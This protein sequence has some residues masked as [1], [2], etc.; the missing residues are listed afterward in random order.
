MVRFRTGISGS[1]LGGIK[2]TEECL[3]FCGKHNIFSET[4]HVEAN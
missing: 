1:H 4:L 2:A 3:E